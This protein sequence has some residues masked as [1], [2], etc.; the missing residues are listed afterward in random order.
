MNTH[1]N[2]YDNPQEAEGLQLENIQ[3]KKRLEQEEFLHKSLYRQW[4]ELNDRIL[5][6]ERELS[7]FN[8]RNLFYKY[9]FYVILFALIPAYYFLTYGKEGE[10]K[11]I[12]A[13]DIASSPT[14]VV[15]QSP[16]T[17]SDTVKVTGIKP[18]EENAIQPDIVN[19]KLAPVN[20]PIV[21]QPFP[22]NEIDDKPVS[23]DKSLAG[24]VRDSVYSQGWD[25]YYKQTRNPYQRSSKKYE[26]WL[27]GWKDGE[28]GA[29]KLTAKD[30]LPH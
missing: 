5:A 29:K 15:N 23:N 16:I 30:S 28:N 12:P 3:L 13:S 11:N 8:S 18:A 17:L 22:G 21:Y 9:A 6:K 25:A 7:Q 27:E 4:N 10:K 1:Q 24:S 14:P 20:K 19:Q 2:Y 26:V